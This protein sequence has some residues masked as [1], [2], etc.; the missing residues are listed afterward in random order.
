MNTLWRRVALALLALAGL[1]VGVWAAAAPRS[2]YDSFPSL[3]YHWID[4]L[5]PFNEHLVFDVGTLQLGLA[6]GSLA[7]IVS[8]RALLG[9]LSGLTWFVFALPHFAF[10]LARLGPTMSDSIG[11]AVSTGLP[12]VLGL[13]LI[14]PPRVRVEADSPLEIKE[15]AR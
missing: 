13:L 7:A 6:A 2:F 11:Q 12:V 9:R 14:P 4:L 8:R 5:P 3:G 1:F 15:I 10:H